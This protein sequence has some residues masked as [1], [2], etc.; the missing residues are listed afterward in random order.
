MIMK[1]DAIKKH[2]AQIANSKTVAGLMQYVGGR[3]CEELRLILGRKRKL[4]HYLHERKMIDTDD[5]SE[6]E[7]AAFLIAAADLREHRPKKAQILIAIDN[8]R[9]ARDAGRPPKGTIKAKIYGDLD[10]IEAA[11]NAGITWKEILRHLKRRSKYKSVR[12]T[13]DC[14][15]NTTA[16]LLKERQQRRDAAQQKA[17]AEL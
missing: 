17:S 13:A 3:T 14:L 7:L 9:R 2:L 6:I 16:K 15:R 5:N 10:D 8:E 1:A 12:I 11:R 4:Y